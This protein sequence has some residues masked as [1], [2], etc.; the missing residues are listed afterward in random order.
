ML[1]ENTIL[2]LQTLGA[3]TLSAEPRA[4]VLGTL[5]EAILKAAECESLEIWLEEGDATR[6]WRFPA[7]A[8]PQDSLP[9]SRLVGRGGLT[10][11]V[12]GALGQESVLACSGRRT[13]W[14]GIW[15][16]SEALLPFEV[17]TQIQGVLHFRRGSGEGEF[18]PQEIEQAGV[19]ARALGSKL[20]HQ[21]TQAAL[22]ERV[23]ELT[24]VYR[25]AQIA[26]EPAPLNDV[27]DRIVGVLPAGWQH[28]AATSARVSVGDEVFHS[29]GFQVSSEVLRA[30]ILRREETIGWVEVFQQ[31]SESPA[32]FLA[33]ERH[34]LAAVARELSSLIE[35]K[36]AETDRARLRDHLHHADRLATIG[37]LSAGV[38]HELNE[39]LASILGF[40]Q[41]ASKA[42]ELRDSTREDVERVVKASLYA[43]EIIRNLLVFSRQ[44]P[45]RKVEA[46][47]ESALEQAIAL[48]EPRCAAASVTLSQELPEAL[49][50]IQADPA[51]LQQ[52]FLNL[53]VNA[54]QSMPEGGELD[55]TARH[56]DELIL[57]RV[58]DTGSGIK[59]EDLEQIFLP[60][61]T[62][63]D[64]GEGTGLG[65]SVVHGIVTAHGGS[66]SVTSEVGRGSCFEVALPC[67]QREEKPE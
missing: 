44:S 59:P 6:C 26:A 24:C 11:R 38:A 39:P 33:E 25:I 49:P 48:V 5:A 55:V 10:D 20:G 19:L 12:A 53:L 61:F 8:A 9:T 65:L 50:R 18:N 22:I 13:P 43:R 7:S 46:R 3:P 45:Q 32:P 1:H 28:P 40:A 27:L 58:R 15:T 21:Q 16:P 17:T 51:Q 41:L 31:D 4:K 63:K 35:R 36:E 64:V 60:F 47:V 29:A 57:V 30:P 42:P 2:L 67:S 56:R 14:G 62:T 66:L 54:V 37:L 52:V 23:K 34:L